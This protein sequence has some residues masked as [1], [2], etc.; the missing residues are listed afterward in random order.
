MESTVNLTAATLAHSIKNVK[1]NTE[2]NWYNSFIAKLD[3]SYFGLIS[4]TILIGSIIGGITASV[5]LSSNA[6]VWQLGLCA[7]VSMANNTAGIGQAPT[8]WVF[9]L[10]IGSFI[11][12]VLLI[13]INIL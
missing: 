5:V 10:F 9:N 12:N 13:I 4:M 11:T 6:P 1:L 3:F 2:S 7:A 8:K